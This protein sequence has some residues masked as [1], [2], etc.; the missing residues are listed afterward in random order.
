MTVKLMFNNNI[1]LSLQ[2]DIQA[3][4][5]RQIIKSS[6]TIMYFVD[7]MDSM[8]TSFM[9]PAEKNDLGTTDH[10]PRGLFGNFGTIGKI[11]NFA[12]TLYNLTK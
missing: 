5:N 3:P 7:L 11:V 9:G 4:L 8:L 1:F 2:N 12:Q 6:E 10:H